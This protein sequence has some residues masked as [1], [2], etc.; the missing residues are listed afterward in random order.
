[1]I[2]LNAFTTYVTFDRSKSKTNPS[3]VLH[4]VILTTSVWLYAVG[5]TVVYLLYP[6]PIFHHVMYGGVLL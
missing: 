6:N 2:Y 4:Q 5:V 3:S 1:M